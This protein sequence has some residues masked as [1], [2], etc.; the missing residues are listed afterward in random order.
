MGI[1]AISTSESVAECC[2]K[3]TMLDMALDY[4]KK[5]I[6]LELLPAVCSGMATGYVQ[7]P[8]CRHFF[9]MKSLFPGMPQ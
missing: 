1:N 3:A 5:G 2:V 7:E 9:I 6:K 8:P 4:S